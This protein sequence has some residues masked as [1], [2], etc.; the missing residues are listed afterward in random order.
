LALAP[1]CRTGQPTISL[2]VT[3]TTAADIEVWLVV[4]DDSAGS[5]GTNEKINTEFQ[6]HEKNCFPCHETTNV[7][8]NKQ[9]WQQRP[10]MH[11]VKT[12]TNIVV[13]K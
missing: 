7:S 2:K 3:G 10:N 13:H 8:N 9:I 5:A 4:V 6:M 1:C 12:T 11:K